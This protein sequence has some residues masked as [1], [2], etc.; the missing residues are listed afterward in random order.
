[1]KCAKRWLL[2]SFTL[3]LLPALLLAQGL[4]PKSI[5]NPPRGSW[6]TYNGDYSGR[7]FSPLKQINQET[8]HNLALAWAFST[9]LVSGGGNINSIKATPLMVDGVVYF[10]MPDHV[11][12][13][14][15]R[16]GK[17][18]WNYEWMSKG[19]IHIGNR[20]VGIYRNWLFFETPDDHLVLPRQEH[21][22]VPLEPG[23]RRP[24]SGIFLN[25]CATGDRQP[26][27]RW[28]RR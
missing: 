8:I 28:C 18:I 17:E 20:G 5:L 6:P 11:W 16:T 26:P 15:A 7:R 12:A 9:G 2:L 25:R 21:R 24:R 1:M 27:D 19:G 22:Q 13:A 14:D 3:A 10:T 23:N 4:D